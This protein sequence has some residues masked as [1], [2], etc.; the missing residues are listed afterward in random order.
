MTLTTGQVLNNRYRIVRLLG[1]GGFGAV[2]R[3]WDLNL[4]AP[5]AVKENF[6]VSPDAARQFAREASIL[7]N[8]HHPNL[9]RVTDHFSI[10]GQGQYLVMD[11]V[12]GQDVNEI[13][14]ASSGPLPEA[15]VL[16][17]ARQVCDALEYLHTR[18]PPIVH[19][20]IKPANI[21]VR[22]DGLVMLVDFGIA[23]FYDPSMRTTMG[24]RAV[25]PGYSPFEQYGQKPTDARTDIYALG[26]TLYTLLTGHEPIESIERVSGSELPPIR[27]LNPQVSSNT[28]QAILK[29]MEIFPQNRFQ[30][31][32]EFSAALFNTP[33]QPSL[34]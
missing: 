15:Q 33:S 14:L 11:Y 17:I 3:A 23:K 9:P 13:C 27:A 32:R 26:A 31:A 5:C 19:R 10:P 20:D 7:A 16:D 1:S 6:D 25:T 8:L 34:I 28:E 24:A 18:T 12:E 2:Y 22:T 29:A 30:T 4:S 21:R